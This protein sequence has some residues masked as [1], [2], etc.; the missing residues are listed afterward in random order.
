MKRRNAPTWPAL[1]LLPATLLAACPDEHPEVA[2]DGPDAGVTEV[3]GTADDSGA[4]GADT[5]A[6]RDALEAGDGGNPPRDAMASDAGDAGDVAPPPDD[7]DAAGPPACDGRDTCPAS[8]ARACTGDLSAVRTCAADADGCL[9]W[10]ATDACAAGEACADAADGTATCVVLCADVAAEDACAEV[11]ARRCDGDRLETC[12][13]D[14]DGCQSFAEAVD[15]ALEAGANTCGPMGETVACVFDVCADRD[16][17]TPG[18][19]CDGEILTTCDQDAFGCGV[20]R[21]FDCGAAS[22]VCDGDVGRC[23]AADDPCDGVPA[24]A[25]CE[26]G[27]GAT[28][29]P[30]APG[31][32]RACV[33]DAF[34][35]PI[36]VVTDCIATAPDGGLGYCDGSE[37]GAA[38][39]RVDLADRCAGKP[40]CVQA[41]GPGTRCDATDDQILRCTWDA[42]GCLVETA[43]RCADEDPF[44]VCV[45]AADGSASCRRP[46]EDACV[47]GE[48][49]CADDRVEVCAQGALGCLAFESETDCAEDGWLCRE[50][51]GTPA[52]VL[53][54][55]VA[56]VEPNERCETATPLNASGLATGALTTL[57]TDWYVLEITETSDLRAETFGAD[58]TGCGGDTYLTLYASD[59]VTVLTDDDDSGNANCSRIDP[60]TDAF[61]ALLEPGVYYLRVNAYGTG[62]VSAY[63][64]SVVASLPVCGNGVLERG[65]TCD[66]GP[67]RPGDGCDPGCQVLQGWSCNGAPSVCVDLSVGDTCATAF[68]LDTMLAGASSGVFGPFPNATYRDDYRGFNNTSCPVNGGAG[69][70]GTGGSGRDLVF[71]VTVAPGE[72]LSASMAN[73]DFDEYIALVSDCGTISPTTCLFADDAPG[74]L[75]WVNR[76]TEPRTVF[77]VADAW[78]ST[79]TGQFTLQVGLRTPVCGDGLLEGAEGCDGGAGGTTGCSPACQTEPGYLCTG[80]PSVCMVEGVGNTCATAEVIP[81]GTVLGSS[82]GASGYGNAYNNYGGGCATGATAGHDR[83]YAVTVPSNHQLA[84]T[85][86]PSGYDAVLALSTN[87]AALTAQC[88]LRRDVAN[89]GGAESGSYANTSGAAQVVYVVA[90]AA[91]AGVGGDFSLAVALS[92]LGDLTV[93]SEPN[94]TCAQADPVTLEDRVVAAINPGIEAD[95]FTFTLATSRVVRIET[96]G[97]AGPGSPCPGDTRIDLYADATCSAVTASDDDAG[98]EAC[99]LLTR[100]LAAGTYRVRVRSWGAA[101]GSYALQVS[102]SAP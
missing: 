9:V 16:T 98:S 99:S 86:T 71:R 2:E 69:T 51:D 15:C 19:R 42:V 50:V 20:A 17:C 39:C 30:N 92:Q 78:T 23:V 56:E 27:D 14:A 25:R 11:G 89:V 32:L 65:E 58:F 66:V 75:T 31:Q 61:A 76:A 34:G 13:E 41:E 70:A 54:P 26:P 64:L 91:T 67:D 3:V 10:S 18:A 36:R 28:C 63:G 88:V 72:I 102:T 1:L 49:R 68:D 84:V 94:D 93:E 24:E 35:C 85:Y 97:G 38:M 59:C 46:C 57:D 100:T 80:A 47:E 33:F 79:N 40:Q 45:S 77:I 81:A 48:V 12:T 55:P 60:R 82:R 62:P 29:D 6:P 96:T 44:H 53:P 74:D 37:P 5:S 4:L 43:E 83:V 73:N 90:D 95:F 87:C 21:T 7:A 22:A 8:G 52:C 101:L